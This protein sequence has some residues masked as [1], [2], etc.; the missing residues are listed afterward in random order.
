MKSWWKKNYA[1]VLG[2]NE[3]NLA[4]VYTRN[5]RKYFDLANDKVLTKKILVAADIPVARQLA[6][7]QRVGEIEDLW[8]MMEPVSCAIKPAHGSGGGGIL[9]LRR[10]QTGW[11]SNGVYLEEPVIHKHIANII[12][13]VFS[14]G[15]DDVAL[16]EEKIEPHSAITRIFDQGVADL[17][18]IVCDDKP[19]MAMLRIPTAKSGGKANLHQGALGVGID[20][21]TGRTTAAFNGEEYMHLHPDSK[22]PLT[23][24]TV[25]FWTECLD[26]AVRT[27]RTVPLDYLGI[28]IAFDQNL[29]PLVLE[30]NVRPGLEIQN[31]NQLGLKHVLPKS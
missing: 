22:Q 26:I 4:W 17:R 6:V 19:I 18:I 31:V 11:R 7:I 30:I 8:R 16:I 20:I 15:S 1:N 23:D 21:K 28:D 9:V 10:D 14:F 12:F 24:F 29:G 13:G 3:R 25:P 5:P 2:I 27:A